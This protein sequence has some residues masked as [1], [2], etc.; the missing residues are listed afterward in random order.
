MG[1]SRV[2]QNQLCKKVRVHQRQYTFDS[3]A[4]FVLAEILRVPRNRQ[5][6]LQRDPFQRVIISMQNVSERYRKGSVVHC[7]IASRFDLVNMIEAEPLGASK[8]H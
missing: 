7:V 5:P 4:H 3:L 2:L 8:G 6:Q 1:I